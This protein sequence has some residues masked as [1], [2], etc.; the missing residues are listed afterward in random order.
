MTPSADPGHPTELT[1]R[2]LK[3]RVNWRRDSSQI[4]RPEI[5]IMTEG[6][7]HIS[8]NCP[9]MR[10]KHNTRLEQDRWTQICCFVERKKE[11][12]VEDEEKIICSGAEAPR[13]RCR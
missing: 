9:A 2:E 1:R 11:R 5:D 8:S 13:V 6:W 10:P 3:I 7:L 12:E 4:C